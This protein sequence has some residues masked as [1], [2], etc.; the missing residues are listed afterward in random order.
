MWVLQLVFTIVQS[1]HFQKQFREL[2][3]QLSGFLGVG[4]SRRRF[5][6]GAVVILVTDEHGVVTRCRQMAG[7]SVFARFR[8]VSE[9]IGKRLEECRVPAP[10]KPKQ[11]A[12]NM[13]IDKITQEQSRKQQERSADEQM[14]EAGRGSDV[15]I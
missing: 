14:D 3:Q 12:L 13:A 2:Q 4:V 9:L 7:I 5:G 10:T 11:L 8:E 15:N 1:N 6:S